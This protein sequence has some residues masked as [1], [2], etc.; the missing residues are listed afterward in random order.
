[1]MKMKKKIY[2]NLK[3]KKK[4]K[5]SKVHLQESGHPLLSRE[6]VESHRIIHQE[7]R[8]KK[9][10]NNRTEKTRM[11]NRIH[12]KLQRNTKVHHLKA[13]NQRVDHLNIQNQWHQNQQILNQCIRKNWYKERAVTDYVYIWGLCC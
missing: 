7:S 1:M 3:L 2:L 12:L 4:E 11:R 5:T 6:H 13:I 10:E 8:L 9:R